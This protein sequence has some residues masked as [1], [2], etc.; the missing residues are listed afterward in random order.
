[1]SRYVDPA[2][3][4]TLALTAGPGNPCYMPPECRVENPKYTVKLDIFSF[5]ILVVHTIIGSVPNSYDLSILRSFFHSIFGQ[6]ELKRRSTTIQQK[7]GEDH[8]LYPLTARCLRD[9]PEQRPSAEV[10]SSS[11]RELCL[12]HPRMVSGVNALCEV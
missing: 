8:C 7:M 2:S 1:M 4:A 10:V 11:L 3:L 5:G 6:V 9:R 12:T